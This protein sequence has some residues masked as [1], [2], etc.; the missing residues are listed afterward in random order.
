MTTTPAA[1]IQPN[2]PISELWV[3]VHT[4][5]I[6]VGDV[7]RVKNNAYSGSTGSIHN[8]RLCEVVEICNG[9][10]IVK[11][12]DNALPELTATHHP[13]YNLEKLVSLL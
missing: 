3:Q 12:I 13:S 11:S 10:V 8:G 1:V 7:V 2:A 5:N 4:G 6:K 9:D